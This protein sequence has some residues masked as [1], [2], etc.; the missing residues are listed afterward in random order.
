MLQKIVND[1]GHDD[2]IKIYTCGGAGYQ[3][4]SFRARSVIGDYKPTLIIMLIGICEITKRDNR[5]K[6]TQLRFDTVQEI[7]EHVIRQARLSLDLLRQYGTHYISYATITGLDLQHYNVRAIANHPSLKD[8]HD[9]QKHQLILNQAILE[10]NQKIVQL[11]TELRIPTTW[12][13]GYV[14]RYFRKKH[15]NYYRRLKD[16]C[17]PT[18]EAAR[19]WVTQILK[20][21]EKVIQAVDL[22]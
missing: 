21:S 10:A 15:H 1:L 12:A 19:Y 13:A 22:K 17:H 5:T 7:V 4:A 16:G 8:H 9:P 14:H 6:L 18:E 3:R 2:Q 11:N 20:T